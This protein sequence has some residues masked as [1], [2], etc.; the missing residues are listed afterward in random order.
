MKCLV[1]GGNGHLGFNLVR[2]LSARGHA[3]RTTVRSR[4]D[5]EKSARLEALGGVELA[6]ADVRDERAMRAAL[7]GLDTL[8][9]VAAVYSTAEPHRDAEILDSALRGTETALRAAAFAGVTRVVLTSSV[10]TLPLTPP[11]APPVTE[12]D[13]AT[14]LRVAYFRAK[15]QS[16]HLAWRLADELGLSLAT[17]LPAGILGPGF[18]RNTPT[19]D[20]IEACLMGEFRLGAPRGNFSFVDVRDAADAH[21]LAAEQGAQGR[22]I[23]GYEA[24]PSFEQLV[25]TLGTIDPRVKPPLMVLPSV[26]APILPLYDRLSHRLMGTPRTAT[27]EVIA[28][29]VSGKVWNFSCERARRELGWSPRIPFEESLRETVLA[30]SERSGCA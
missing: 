18:A 9:H 6:E 28:T 11:G 20:L 3:V 19:L 14:D 27:P 17:I 10:V 26:L 1:T 29:A 24:A 15:T 7:E 25:R 13:W 16:E 12:E 21:V 2:I 22:F 23:V 4:S 30:L 8:F 5:R